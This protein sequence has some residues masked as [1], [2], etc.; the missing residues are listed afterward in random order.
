MVGVDGIVAVQLKRN[1][2]QLLHD[3]VVGDEGRQ[4]PVHF[5]KALSTMTCEHWAKPG[6]ARD[7][8]LDYRFDINTLQFLEIT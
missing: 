4:A 5:T 6:I 1:R 2:E 8:V 3:A 7:K